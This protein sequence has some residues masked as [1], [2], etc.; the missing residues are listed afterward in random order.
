MKRGLLR[1][2]LILS[3]CLLAACQSVPDEPALYEFDQVVPDDQVIVID[4]YD[5]IEPVNRAMYKFN[6][7]FDKML[8]VPITQIYEFITPTFVQDRVTNFFSNLTELSTF[9]NSI[10]QGKLT[11]ASRALVRFVVNTTVG[12]AG[13]FDPMAA[14]G[15]AQERED[16]GQTLGTWG[17]GNGPYIVLPIF[18]PS[19]LRDTAGLVGDTVAYQAADPGG[20]ASFESDHPEMT[21]LRAIDKRHNI[22]FRYYETGS[23]FEYDLV[24][25][26]YTKKRQLD[27]EK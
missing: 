2:L 5:P 25:L 24:R 13:L 4:V 9:A 21:L 17:F 10:L 6:A 1:S 8:F 26:L 22:A 12:L 27:I 23:P 20:L 19:N 15:T 3:I 16:F 18:G 11:R 14:L 7:V